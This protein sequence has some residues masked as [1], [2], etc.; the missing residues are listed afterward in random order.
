[1][2]IVTTTPTATAAPPASTVRTSV[3]AVR[4]CT[5]AKANRP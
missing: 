4:A 2:R 1:M 5:V 3:P